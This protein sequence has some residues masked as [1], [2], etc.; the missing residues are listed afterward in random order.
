MHQITGE[1]GRSGGQ[2]EWSVDGSV[3]NVRIMTLGL[4]PISRTIVEDGRISRLSLVFEG[5]AGLAQSPADARFL[6]QSLRLGGFAR[7]T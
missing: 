3:F 7:H 2:K 4:N 5:R 6:D 1:G